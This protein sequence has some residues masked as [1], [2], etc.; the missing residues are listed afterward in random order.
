MISSEYFGVVFDYDAMR[1]NAIRALAGVEYDVLVGTGV[2]G[3]LGV[4]VLGALL[5]KPIAVVR[6]DLSSSHSSKI[7]EGHILPRFIVVDDFTASG[8]TVERVRDIYAQDVLS[9]AQSP[10][11]VGTYMYVTR[12]YH[13]EL[14]GLFRRHAE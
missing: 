11:Y 4:G 13:T 1:E 7:V 2:S 3:T 12:N 5:N 10:L 14:Q 6:K 9:S 8:F